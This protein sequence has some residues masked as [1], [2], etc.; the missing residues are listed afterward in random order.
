MITPQVDALPG[1]APLGLSAYEVVVGNIGVAH[2]ST[3]RIEALRVYYEYADLSA[4]GYGRAA[5]EP[6]TLMRDGDIDRDNCTYPF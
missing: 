4:T 6:V 3:S 2:T 1:M 5:H